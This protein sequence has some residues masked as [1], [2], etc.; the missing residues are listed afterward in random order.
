MQIYLRRGARPFINWIAT[1]A[2]PP[3]NDKGVMKFPDYGGHF[4]G[5][6]SPLLVIARNES[7]E[8]IQL[9]K[10][11]HPIYWIATGA[12]PPRNDKGGMNCS[13]NGWRSCGEYWQ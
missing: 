1:G 8:A 12:L 6:S 9:I 2:L 7:D 11:K 5:C 4:L 3:R 10:S 13:A